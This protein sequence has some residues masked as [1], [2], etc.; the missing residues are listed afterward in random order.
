MNLSK[1]TQGIAEQSK[2]TH[3]PSRYTFLDLKMKL[4]MENGNRTMCKQLHTVE[5]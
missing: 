1:N 5:V 4:N 3:H 2:G